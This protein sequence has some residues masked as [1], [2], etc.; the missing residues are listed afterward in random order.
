[1]IGNKYG[2]LL[3]IGIS[4]KKH[5]LTCKC[6]CGVVKDIYKSSLTRGLSKSCGCNRVKHNETKTNLFRLWSKMLERCYNKNHVHYN[7]YGGRGIVVCDKWK[8]DFLAFKKD[9]GQRPSRDHSV[10]R[11]KNDGNY[12]PE[13]VK[14]STKKEQGNNSRQCHLIT[15]EGVTKN[16]TQWAEHYGIKR[17]R[18]YDRIKR[19][20][21]DERAVIY[22][23]LY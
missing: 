13:N 18:I 17:D 12:E 3:V 21:S 11:I 14:W 20:Y 2:K 10:D 22:S 5:H 23:A 4:T 16:I 8:N 7:N 1:M 19:G 9:I 15:I 6:D